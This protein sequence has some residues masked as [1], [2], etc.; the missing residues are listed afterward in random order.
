MRG[1]EQRQHIFQ[2]RL[3]NAK[4]PSCSMNKISEERRETRKKRQIYLKVLLPPMH[5]S[6]DVQ[7]SHLH[8]LVS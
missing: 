1:N 3:Q 7:I 6:A 8:Q 4:I 5:P 2:Q